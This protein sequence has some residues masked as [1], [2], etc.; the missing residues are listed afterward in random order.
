MDHPEFLS[1]DDI[2]EIH[3]DQIDR[4]GGSNGIRDLNGL[5]SAIEQP[6][7][8]FRNEFLHSDIWSMAAAYIFHI[9]Q[10]HP[11]IDGNKRT[12]LVSGLIFLDINGYEILDPD[13]LLYGKIIEVASGKSSKDKVGAILR[14]LF[15]TGSNDNR[16][17]RIL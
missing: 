17:M 1:L 12:S 3:Q 7:T 10:N 15:E 5:L 11:F 14:Q 4:Y 2:L 8:T 9:S 6:R 16:N 13:E